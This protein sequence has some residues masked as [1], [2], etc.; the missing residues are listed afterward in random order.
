MIALK[1]ILVPIDF[2]GTSR[3]ALKYGVALA[4]VFS[5][6]LYLLHVPEDPGEVPERSRSRVGR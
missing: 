6:R 3:A 1:R 4:R 5:A 2:G